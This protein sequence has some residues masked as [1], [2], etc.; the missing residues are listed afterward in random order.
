MKETIVENWKRKVLEW[1]KEDR[2]YLVVEIITRA[3]VILSV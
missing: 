3:F 2:V 1:M